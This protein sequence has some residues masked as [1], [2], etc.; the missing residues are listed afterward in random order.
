[1]HIAFPKSGR[2]QDVDVVVISLHRGDKSASFC[3]TRLLI[4]LVRL[5]L[6]WLSESVVSLISRGITKLGVADKGAA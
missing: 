3:Y 2:S 4:F 1:M 5:D 6:P